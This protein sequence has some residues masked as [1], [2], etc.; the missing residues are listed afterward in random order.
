MENT[1]K[2]IKL[3]FDVEQ[4]M[5]EAANART[6]IFRVA[7]ELFKRIAVSEEVDL[8]LA[9]TENKGNLAV[10]LESIG[11]PEL[12][13]KTVRLPYAKLMTK[14]KNVFQKWRG[15][16]FAK[17]CKAYYQRLLKGFDWYFSPF[18]PI[19]IPVYKSDVKT[20]V[21][22]HDIIPIVRPDLASKGSKFLKKYKAWMASVDTDLVVFNS[23]S[24]QKDFLNFRKDIMPQ[25]TMVMYL[26]ADEKFYPN[27]DSENSNRIIAKYGLEPKKYVLS[28]S[29]QNKRKNIPHLICSFIRF[30]KISGREDIVLAVAGPQRKGCKD[31]ADG[32]EDFE[33]YQKQI[34]NLG[35]V[36]E[37]DIAALYSNALFFVYPSLYEGFG[38]PV[39][40]A[41]KCGAPVVCSDNSSLPEVGGD[42]VFYI[43]GTDE[44]QTADAL[45][46]MCDNEV[47]RRN[48][49]E[50]GLVRSAGFSWDKAALQLMKAL[51]G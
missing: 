17:C 4:L 33:K 30:L 11:H 32:I 31:V 24:S 50:K 21:M 8:Y 37:E 29:D 45:Q 2:K 9:V 7:D 35:F 27:G 46:Q 51:K 14:S 15:K 5:K 39:L 26:G 25:R 42:A 48:L 10:Y 28:L 12:E 34:V 18:S 22:V 41:M 23:V 40:E 36:D 16:F 1:G 43:N 20:A 47:L 19:A 3:L 13:A 49:S 38:L 6:G 44:V